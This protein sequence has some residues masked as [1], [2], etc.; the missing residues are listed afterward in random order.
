MD[1]NSG[2]ARFFF[3]EVC[4]VCL[5]KLD[6]AV[7][8]QTLLCRPTSH[9]FKV[10]DEFCRE[11][12]RGFAGH[13]SLV[14]E[15]EIEVN[16]LLKQKKRDGDKILA[17]KIENFVKSGATVGNMYPTMIE[18]QAFFGLRCEELVSADVLYRSLKEL[19]RSMAQTRRFSHAG[20]FLHIMKTKYAFCE[21]D[22]MWLDLE[23]IATDLELGAAE[24]SLKNLGVMVVP[25][26]DRQNMRK[27]IELKVRALVALGQDSK[28]LAVVKSVPLVLSDW[29]KCNGA[30]FEAADIVYFAGRMLSYCVQLEQHISIA[31]PYINAVVTFSARRRCKCEECLCSYSSALHFLIAAAMHYDIVDSIIGCVGYFTAVFRDA[32]LNP[33]VD[34]AVPFCY[35]MGMLNEFQGHFE[36]AVEF[37]MNAVAEMKHRYIGHHYLY[38]AAL[39][40]LQRCIS[41]CPP[42]AKHNSNRKSKK[43]N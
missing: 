38:I 40:S 33:N 36:T 3:E 25:R 35:V 1:F 4:F 42:P 24:R 8:K 18:F 32:E 26:S 27:S 6:G 19:S 29:S 23:L 22:E 16:R 34:V 39:H 37:Y 9:R 7:S 20:G 43:N 11:V 14:F 5:A 13:C 41:L 12:Y 10:C 28:A 15:T 30:E 31:S 2:T 17:A 21:T